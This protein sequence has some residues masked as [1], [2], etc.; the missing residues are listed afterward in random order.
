[1]LTAQQTAGTDRHQQQPTGTPTGRR[2]IPLSQW[3]QFHPWPTVSALRHLRF[4][5]HENG[6]ARA[7]RTVGRRVLV[8][9]AE[10]FAAVDRQ[11]QGGGES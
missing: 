2:L 8:D 3:E 5:M 10:F 6:F 1:M 4:N 11:Q 7:F 9:E